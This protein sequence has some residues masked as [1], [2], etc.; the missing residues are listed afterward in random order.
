MLF[1][2]FRKTIN[3]VK[4]LITKT[5]A[6]IQE[7]CQK[8]APVPTSAANTPPLYKRTSPIWCV[9][10]F[11]NLFLAKFVRR[12]QERIGIANANAMIEMDIGVSMEFNEKNPCRRTRPTAISAPDH[13]SEG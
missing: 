12:L 6:E 11:P 13:M 2:T 9:G 8:A 5:R 1:G 7:I 4:E 3:A 10:L